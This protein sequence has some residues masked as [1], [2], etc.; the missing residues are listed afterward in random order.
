M[1]FIQIF[2]K[3]I[4][5]FAITVKFFI[6]QIFKLK[7]SIIK[8]NNLILIHQQSERIACEFLIVPNV[9]Y[10]SLIFPFLKLFKFHQLVV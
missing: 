5:T 9:N 7:V 1:K 10:F 4:N 2:L 8:L 6:R 3:G